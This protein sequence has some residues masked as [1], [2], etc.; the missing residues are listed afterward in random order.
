MLAKYLAHSA[1]ILCGCPTF[2]SV[3]SASPLP[4]PFRFQHPSAVNSTFQ[5]LP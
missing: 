2:I 4:K 3:V 5:G 1:A